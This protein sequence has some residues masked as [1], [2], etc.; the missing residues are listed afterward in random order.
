MSVAD[1]VPRVREA[2]GISASYEAEIIPALIRRQIG[3]LLR[4]Y[5]FPKQIVR[6]EFP[7]T[8]PTAQT[9]VLP[10][11]F[12]KELAVHIFDP[13]TT[14]WSEPLKKREGMVPQTFEPDYYW[15]QGGSLQLNTPMGPNGV[16]MKLVVFFQSM[17]PV[18]NEDWMTEDFEDVVF[19]LSVYRGSI[20][21]RKPD[22][23]A[24]FGQLWKEDQASLAIYVN[25]L[26]FSNLD[27]IQRETRGIYASLGGRLLSGNVVSGGSGGAVGNAEILA[28]QLQIDGL[29]VDLAQKNALI[30]TLNDQI[31]ALQNQAQPTV[32]ELHFSTLFRVGVPIV[33]GTISGATAGS[34]I[35][36]IAG[37]TIT[38]NGA[39][40]RYDGTPQV[41]GDQDFIET[42]QNANGSPYHTTVTVDPS[43]IVAP[44]YAAGLAFNDPR[45]SMYL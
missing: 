1:L 6:V 4:D 9:F 7:V 35:T 2:L 16:G 41:A 14:L 38:G 12:K 18:L 29:E 32:S 24:A 28:L 27:M 43:V 42:L 37:I 5:N 17:D 20:E 22:V 19:T 23:G 26:E 13:R 39:Q 45:N 8:D 40:R 21:Q 33:N 30:D 11:G 10:A 44:P 25:E 36:P 15:L 3:R 31:A 34:V